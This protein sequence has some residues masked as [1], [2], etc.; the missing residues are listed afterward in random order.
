M[1]YGLYTRVLHWLL[2]AAI[3]LQMLLSLV[4][5]PPHPGRV[6]TAFE[7][8][9]YDAHRYVGVAVL[10]I[11]VLHWLLF[12]SGN[13]HKGWGHFF[14]WFSRER[15]TAVFDDI[16]GLLRLRIENP[17]QQD[18]L[19]GGIQGLGLLVGTL[20][21]ASGLVLFLGMASDGA[22]SATVHAIAEF[23]SFWGP[24]MWGYLGL[25][26]GAVAIHLLSGHRSVLNI[27]RAS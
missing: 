15:R 17:E 21:A 25:H 11:V 26:V 7:N 2:A 10:A 8:L 16:K 19:A 5:R 12:I 24:V 14:P 13:A 6:H 22:M 4:M 1:K 3:S 18:S 20:L 9:T 27:F 23:H